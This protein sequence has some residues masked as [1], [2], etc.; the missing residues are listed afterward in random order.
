MFHTLEGDKG[1]NSPKKLSA[2]TERKL[3]LVKEKLQNA[4]VDCVDPKLNYSLVMSPS[5]HPTGVLVHREDI[6]L[7]W[8]LF[9]LQT[10]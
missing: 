2:E 10:E 5:S 4:R 7:E 1:L 8:I 6:I 3:A 9:T